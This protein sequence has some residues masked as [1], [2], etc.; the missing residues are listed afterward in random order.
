V[1]LVLGGTTEARS[2]AA[3]FGERGVDFVSSRTTDYRLPDETGPR[4]R[5]RFDDGSLAQFLRDRGID[6]IVDATH[7]FAEEISRCA[8]RVSKETGVPLLRFARPPLSL[9]PSETIIRVGSIEGAVETAK[10]IRGR[11]LLTTGV[12]SLSAFV[13]GLPG[14]LDDLVV[15]VLPHSASLAECERLNILPANIVAMQG[16][17]DERFNRYLINRYRAEALVSK[18]SGREGGLEEK[19]RACRETGI[20]LV[21]ISPPR[22]DFPHVVGRIDDLLREVGRMRGGSSAG[23]PPEPEARRK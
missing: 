6:L 8:L 15:R 1:I 14:R 23:H 20:T 11:L 21:L 22:I 17:F 19:L 7:P 13:A 3:A 10:R 16:P 9:P 4:V 2:V 12:R 18:E 5:R